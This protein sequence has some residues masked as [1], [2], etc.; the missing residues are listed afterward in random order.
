MSSTLLNRYAGSD[1]ILQRIGCTYW[2]NFYSKGAIPSMKAADAKKSIQDMADHSQ[3][4]HNE[5]STRG[6]ST[7]TYDGLAA[8]Q[9]QLNN[10]AREIK[11]VNERVYVVQN[12][13]HAMNPTTLRI[14]HL[15][16]NGKHLK[17]HTTPNLEYHSHKEEDI[18]QLLQDSTKET[19]EILRNKSEDKQWKNH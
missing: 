8:I 9:A 11:K 4:W 5:T 3:K 14:V 15:K 16:K 13:N 10:L 18:E 1:L 17:K 12:V 19:M 7:D 6:R 2:T